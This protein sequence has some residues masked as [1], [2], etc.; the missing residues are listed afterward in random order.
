M[1]EFLLEASGLSREFAGFFA[2]GMAAVFM[3]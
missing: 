1:S 3:R 2:F